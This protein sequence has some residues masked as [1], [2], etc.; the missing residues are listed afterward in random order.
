[1]DGGEYAIVLPSPLVQV[2]AR[3]YSVCCLGRGEQ[4]SA[5][6]EN[7]PVWLGASGR[8]FSWACSGIAKVNTANS[9]I[10]RSKNMTRSKKADHRISL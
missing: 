6:N 4:L 3:G 1:M 5:G 8:G 9:A 2:P 10:E 7:L